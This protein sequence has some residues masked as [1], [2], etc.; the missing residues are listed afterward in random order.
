MDASV[1][2]AR[3]IFLDVGTCT[4]LFFLRTPKISSPTVEMFCTSGVALL[5][6]SSGV[7][8]EGPF[9]EH[10]LPARRFHCV[11]KGGFDS[12]V[13]EL[14]ELQK[15]RLAVIHEFRSLMSSEP[16]TGMKLQ[17]ASTSGVPLSASSMHAGTPLAHVDEERTSD[18]QDRSE[19]SNGEEDSTRAGSLH[20]SPQLSAAASSLTPAVTAPPGRLP[21][22]SL[23][24]GSLPAHRAQSATPPGKVPRYNML[25]ESGP[26]SED[27]VN[28]RERQYLDIIGQGSF[29]G[30][31]PRPG[32]ASLPSGST[33]ELPLVTASISQAE[34]PVTITN[35]SAADAPAVPELPR[36]AAEQ[37]HAQK[38]SAVSAPITRSFS[39]PYCQSLASMDFQALA[40][41]E[42]GFLRTSA[43]KDDGQCLDHGLFLGTDPRHPTVLLGSV[44]FVG[45]RQKARLNR[46]AEKCALN[47]RFCVF[48]ARAVDHPV[49][50]ERSLNS[51]GDDCVLSSDVNHVTAVSMFVFKAEINMFLQ[52]V[53]YFMRYCFWRM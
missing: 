29:P 12:G 34:D 40:R 37:M 50:L 33:P 25:G 44:Y 20:M 41:D 9:K 23:G 10:M 22:S 18:V 14:Q 43:S 53:E 48:T 2:F 49:A 28:Q 27:K 26:L 5:Y 24:S 13:A 15:N 6:E 8:E 42:D 51:V 35:D 11:G 39:W 4:I 7:Q 19:N 32:S 38:G 52:H 3:Y 46:E 17:R 36:F 16:M 1:G 30:Q 21:S 47:N 31:I 45:D